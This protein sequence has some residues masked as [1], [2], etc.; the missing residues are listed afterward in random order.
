MKVGIVTTWFERGAAYVSKQFEEVLSKE[1][2]VYIYARG[3]EKYAINDEVWD[4]KNVTWGLRREVSF[5]PTLI[6]KNDFQRWALKNKIEVILFNE[7][8]WWYP[9][10]WCNELKIPTV[11]YV[12]YYR[13]NTIPLFSAYSVLICNTKRHYSAFNWHKNAYYVPWG[14]NCN[15]FKPKGEIGS[16]VNSNEVTFFHSCGMDPYRKGTDI[17]LRAAVA[18]EDLKF[19][20]IIHTQID[21]KLFFDNEILDIIYI[22]E[23]SNKLEIIFKTV[24]APGLFHLGDVYVY[25]SRLEGIGLTIV[26]AQACGL[27]PLVTNNGPMNE[28][29]NDGIGYLIDVDQYFARSDG[30]YWPECIPDVN[31]LINQMIAICENIESIPLMKESNYKYANENLNWDINSKQILEIFKN[32]KYTPIDENVKSKILQYES[33]GFKVLNLY[34]IKF[35]WILNPL[36]KLLRWLLR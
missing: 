9:L 15:L 30:Y 7:Q 5:A 22:L 34:F 29:V 17:F 26:E 19:K 2:D 13:E 35:Y 3:G 33:S 1:N 28:F 20:I 27:I 8:H 16:I 18:I 11:S 36:I 14:T 32:I 23:N 21:L 6:D 12:D 10:L 25:P 31:S 24:S 4:K